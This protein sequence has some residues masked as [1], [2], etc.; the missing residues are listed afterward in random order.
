MHL[1]EEENSENEV[2]FSWDVS[3]F[4]EKQLSTFILKLCNVPFFKIK[5]LKDFI[6]DA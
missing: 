4:L 1:K 3:E 5:N 2:L 6:T